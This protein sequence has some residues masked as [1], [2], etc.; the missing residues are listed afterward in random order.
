MGPQF[1]MALP[2]WKNLKWMRGQAIAARV[3]VSLMCPI[4]VWSVFKYLRLAG[5][6]KNRRLTEIIDPLGAPISATSLIAP[7]LRVIRV[8]ASADSTLVT[9]SMSDTEAMLGRA[10]PLNPRVAMEKRSPSS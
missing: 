5:V 10:S 1:P 3:T 9:I 2:L 8:P 6:L 7:P 4:S